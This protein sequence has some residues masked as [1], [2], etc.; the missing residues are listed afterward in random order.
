MNYNQQLNITYF[1]PYS[2]CFDQEDPFLINALQSEYLDSPSDQGYNLSV[3]SDENSLFG[4][5]GQP[6]FLDKVIFK[7]KVKNG[8][9]IE[10]GADNFETHTNTLLFETEH[11]WSG[12]LVEPHP[13]SYKLGLTKHRKA[14]ASPA[15][16]ATKPRPHMAVFSA[17]SSEGGM[18]GLVPGGDSEDHNIQC[19]PLFS[20]LM[21]LGNTTVNYLSLDMEGAEFLVSLYNFSSGYF[22]SARY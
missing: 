17:K 20:L 11:N 10:A 3:A 14:W 5:F 13:I 9:F 6:D 1:R 22:T 15:C 8:F 21:A 7:G 18:A 2:N 16:L 12:L 19:F 4:Q